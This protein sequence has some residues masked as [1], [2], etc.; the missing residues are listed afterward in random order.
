MAEYIARFPEHA[1]GVRILLAQICVMELQRPAKAIE[2]LARVES[3]RLTEKQAALVKRIRAK[4]NQM[5]QEGDVEL[6]VE[7]W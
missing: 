5:S 7:A 4:A 3:Q 6:D 1:V 2:L